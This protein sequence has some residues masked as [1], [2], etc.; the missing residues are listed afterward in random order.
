MSH[1]PT[2]VTRTKQHMHSPS[3]SRKASKQI[4]ARLFP[5]LEMEAA[6]IA[7]QDDGS[8]TDGR[9]SLIGVAECIDLF[10]AEL[11]EAGPSAPSARS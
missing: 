6:E 7:F 2:S 9:G 1:F 8:S 4:I 11:S 10:G 3:L 5:P